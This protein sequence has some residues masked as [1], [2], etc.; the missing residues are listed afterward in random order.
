MQTLWDKQE[1]LNNLRQ[2]PDAQY[3][4]YGRP[5]TTWHKKRWGFWTCVSH[6]SCGENGR[7]LT[8]FDSF[9]AASDVGPAEVYNPKPKGFKV[10]LALSG[11]P[12]ELTSVAM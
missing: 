12:A 7:E 3:R 8:T 2:I 9:L 4:G 11:M 10:R 6:L 5:Q 1:F